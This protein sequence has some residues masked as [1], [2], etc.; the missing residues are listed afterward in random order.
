[1]TRRL[2]EAGRI[3]GIGLLDH[4]IVCRGEIR[5]VEGKRVCVRGEDDA[6]LVYCENETLIWCGSQAGGCWV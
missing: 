4:V 5:V 3:V 2:V 1:M 6:R